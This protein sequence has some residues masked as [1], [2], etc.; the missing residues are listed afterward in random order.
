MAGIPRCSLKMCCGAFTYRNSIPTGCLRPEP[1]S[2]EC[3]GPVKLVKGARACVSVVRTYSC[4]HCLS[5]GALWCL[6][7]PL[8]RNQWLGSTV[9]VSSNVYMIIRYIV[10]FFCSF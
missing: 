1:R 10:L 2:G 3:I 7:T 4:V 5:T 8:N 9:P 6:L